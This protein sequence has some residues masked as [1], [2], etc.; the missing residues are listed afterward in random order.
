[1]YARVARWEGAKGDSLKRSA[2]EI[3]A[4]ADQGPPEG[5]P[6]KG[7]LV[8][9]DPDSGRSLAIS[10]FETMDDLR[11]GDATLNGMTPRHDDVG[12][13]TSVETYEV[14]VDLHADA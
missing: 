11:E 13:R 8:L 6:A 2:D 5:V 4:R 3:S 10:L 1:M 7:L 9:N 14:A 12:E